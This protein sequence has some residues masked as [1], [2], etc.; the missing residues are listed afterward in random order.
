MRV[1][2]VVVAGF[3]PALELEDVVKSMLVKSLKVES[4][5]TYILLCVFAALR[6]RLCVSGFTHYS[7]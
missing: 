2:R 5:A 4:S 3:S 6:E 7:F 1:R